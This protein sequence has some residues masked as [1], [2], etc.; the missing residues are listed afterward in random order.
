MTKPHFTLTVVTSSDGFIGRSSDETPGA[1]ASPEE[2]ALFLE[3]VAAADWGIMGRRT[4]ELADRP[5]RRRIVFSASGGSGTWRRPSQFW[6][7]PSLASPADLATLVAPVRP[8]ASGLILGGT[9]V[10]DWFASHDAIDRIH[11]SIEPLEFGEGLPLFS[12]HRGPPVAVLSAM[13]FVRCADRL[14]N[15]RGTRHQLW[16]PARRGS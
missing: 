12:A 10:H 11:L 1:W 7:D 14:L 3:D 8:L 9:R 4:H 15:K 13:G 6:L 2:Q 16:L 5:E